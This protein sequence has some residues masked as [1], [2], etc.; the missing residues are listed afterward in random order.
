M[1]RFQLRD[2]RYCIQ[3]PCELVQFAE[4]ILLFSLKNKGGKQWNAKMNLAWNRS[5]GRNKFGDLLPS[6]DPLR[7]FPK[8]ETIS[9]PSSSPSDYWNVDTLLCKVQLQGLVRIFIATTGDEDEG[10]ASSV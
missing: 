3:F 8:R 7:M 1:L 4:K 10:I 9:K 2:L 6:T 5:I